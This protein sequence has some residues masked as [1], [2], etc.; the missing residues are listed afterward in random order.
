MI[1]GLFTVLLSF[2]L[3]GGSVVS[4]RGSSE[5]GEP[6]DLGTLMTLHEDCHTDIN[7]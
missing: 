4:N 6:R 5:F 1:L 3:A 2:I 7:P